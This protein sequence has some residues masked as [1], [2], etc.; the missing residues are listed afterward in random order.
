MLSSILSAPFAT[1]YP[2]LLLAAVEAIERVILIDWPRIS[3]HRG[4]IL[5][6]LV[7]CWCRI[8]EEEELSKELSSVRAKI[9]ECTKLLTA[10]LDQEVDVGSEYRSLIG[11]DSRL[12]ELLVTS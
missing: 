7:V 2:P 6:G 5:R 12:K 3:Y 8:A 11:G 1:A 4:E 10:V 9:K